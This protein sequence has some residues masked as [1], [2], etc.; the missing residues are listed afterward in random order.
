MIV[1]RE[2]ESRRELRETKGGEKKEETG[3]VLEMQPL[4]AS[5]SVSRHSS[6]GNG[7]G[8]SNFPDN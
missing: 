7:N 6:F 5:F 3:C 1:R 8:Q 4:E 2:E